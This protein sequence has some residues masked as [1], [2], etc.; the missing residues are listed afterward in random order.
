[1]KPIITWILI[2]NGANARVIENDGPGHGLKEVSGFDLNRDH[3]PI[4]ETADDRQGRSFDSHGS[5]RHAM[6]P[7]TPIDRI[8]DL[9]F[10]AEL[11]EMLDNALK[12]NAY[13]RLILIAAP[14]TLGDIRGAISDHVA[15]LVYAEVAK[16]LTHVSVHDLSGHVNEYLAV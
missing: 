12:N 10:V 7:S 16:D 2:A 14:R 6:E 1:M 8:D 13:D 11:A 5:G 3:A 9:K 15:K 4:R